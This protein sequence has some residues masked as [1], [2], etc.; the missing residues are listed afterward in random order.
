MA[1]QARRWSC[2]YCRHCRM[3]DQFY[4]DTHHWQLEAEAAT[5]G[6]DTELAEYRQE[7][8][9]PHLADYMKNFR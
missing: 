2:R 6:H 7:H 4:L 3:M 9:P 8:P 5:G 1:A